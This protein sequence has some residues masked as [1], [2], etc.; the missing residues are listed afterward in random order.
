MDKKEQRIELS[1]S[2]IREVYRQGEGAVVA[3]VQ[4]LLASLKRVE[5]LEQRVEELEGQ[6]KKTSE[7]SSKPPS[8]DGFGKRTKSLRRKSGKKS[9]GQKGHHGNTLEWSTEVERVEVHSVEV[10]G[11]CEQSLKGEPVKRYVASQ[12]FDIPEVKLEVVEHRAEVKQCPRCGESSEGSLPDEAKQRVQ[13]GSRLRGV[14][15]Y[16]M[17]SQLLPSQRV[18]ELLA[19]V[20]GAKVSEGTL[21][22]VRRECF[23]KLESLEAEVKERLSQ[24][25]LLHCD[26]TGVRVNSRLYWLHVACTDGLTNYFLH[27]KRGREAINEMGILP[28]FGGKV[29]HDGWRSYQGY[30]CEHFLCNAHHLRELQFVW[31]HYQQPWAVQMS[32][33]LTTILSRVNEARS[34]GEPMLAAEHIRVFEERYDSLIER[35]LADNPIVLPPSQAPRRR[36]RLKRSVPRNL[37]ERLRSHRDSVL[38]FM[39][40]FEVPFDNNQA[41]RDLRMVK[42]KQKISGCFR[43]LSG[44]LMFF[45]IRSCLSSLRKQGRRVLPALVELLSSGRLPLFAVAE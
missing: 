39:R 31:E 44:A 16:L 38:G 17:E 15:V 11:H 22:N 45:R 25:S 10:C 27:A 32:L 8:G 41:E 5:E 40:D 4:K 23:E 9:G 12:V 20:V 13:Y 33:L 37:L 18:C 30:E 19:E 29:V 7:N 28:E 21:Y 1:E 26:E 34:A 42:L 6:K 35:G 43:S 14:M 24:Q 3:L 36:G 2:E